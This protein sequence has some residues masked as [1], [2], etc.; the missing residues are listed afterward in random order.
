MSPR[1][2][3]QTVIASLLDHRSLEAWHCEISQQSSPAYNG[4]SLAPDLS[5]DQIARR[6]WMDGAQALDRHSADFV[7][8]NPFVCVLD[9]WTFDDLRRMQ[10]SDPERQKEQRPPVQRR[11]GLS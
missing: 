3:S 5:Q 11:G 2:F 9:W 1:G 7:E 4:D 8:I 6:E 10:P